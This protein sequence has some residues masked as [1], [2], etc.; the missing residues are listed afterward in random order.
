LGAYRTWDQLSEREHEQV[1]LMLFS[2]KEF[3]YGV[4][5]LDEIWHPGQQV[6][7]RVRFYMTSLHQYC[8]SYYMLSGAHKLKNVLCDLGSGDL[9]TAIDELLQSEL[10]DTTLG[11]VLK[12]FRNKFLTHQS[13]T[14]DAIERDIHAK[15]DL[16]DPR[17]AAK[18]EDLIE[19]LFRATQ[20]LYVNLA[21]RF[22]QTM[23]T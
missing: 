16:D 3:S 20:Q 11:H 23:G 4:D 13:F 12:A 18:L 7:A 19:R 22:P 10:D 5:R 15:F 17:N 6:S 14:T 21:M 2:L 9:L 1:S 8:A